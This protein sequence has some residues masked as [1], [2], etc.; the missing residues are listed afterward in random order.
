MDKIYD[1]VIVG[2][3]PNGLALAWYLAKENKSVLIVE[4]ETSIGGCHRVLRVD[5]LFTE[6]GPRVYSDVYLTFIDLLKEMDLDF[7]DL[8]TLYTFDIS[9]IG[10]KSKTSLKFNEYIAF[11]TSF[12]QLTFNPIYGQN[13][14]MSEFMK[15][16]SFSEESTDYID[17]LCRL[18]DGAEASRYTL[19]QFLQLLNNQILYNLFQPKSPTDEKNGFLVLWENKLRE[20]KLVTILVNHEVS[21]LNSNSNLIE[22]I[23]ILNR[24]NNKNFIVKGK[25]YILSI[26]PKPLQKLLSNSSNQSIQNA[27]GNI[28]TLTKWSIDNS[29]FDYIP[30][31]LHWFHKINLPKIWGFPASEWG[32]A[33]IFLSNYMDF[34]DKT[35]IS[36]CITFTDRK[37]LFTNKTADESTMGEIYTEVLRQLRLV[38]SDLPNPDRMITSPQV[39]R[40]N[41][42]WINID[43]A[44]VT[45]S[46]NQHLPFESNQYTNL[47]N[48]G[49]QNGKSNYHFTSLE[50]AIT[51]SVYLFNIMEPN[52]KYKR[53]IKTY[54]QIRN[55]IHIGI[56][57]LIVGVAIYI[58]KNKIINYINNVN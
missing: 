3:G 34:G 23:N 30:V 52:A 21:S 17:R 53:Y 45:T 58:Y 14:T 57:I 35:V 36:A 22:S 8:F 47:Y 27:F 25:K 13:I 11:I 19:Y 16:N 46:E 9:N 2:G 24:S 6:H 32:L 5:G 44:Y 20:T 18:T 37:S 43:T 55:Y 12:V 56:L 40:N 50:A 26:P 51:N 54:A 7:N 4:R 49:C 1:Y 42:R 28:N 38:Y 48:C 39:Y 41:N 31:T 29:Y 10:S 33:F 15:N